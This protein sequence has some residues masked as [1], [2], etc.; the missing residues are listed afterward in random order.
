MAPMYDAFLIFVV[1]LAVSI[2]V[3]SIA[4]GYLVSWFERKDKDANSTD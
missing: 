3:G 1:G 2:V 4:Y